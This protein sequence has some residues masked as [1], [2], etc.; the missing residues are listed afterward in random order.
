MANRVARSVAL[1]APAPPYM[2]VRVLRLLAA[3]RLQPD[4]GSCRQNPPP[5]RG[6]TPAAPMASAAPEPVADG[7]DGHGYGG[8]AR[9]ATLPS[10]LGANTPYQPY[11][12]KT[13][14]AG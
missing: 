2:R 5:G 4:V 9:L 11:W 14:M 12:A 1:P 7:R 8:I 3:H 6:A 10:R 13:K